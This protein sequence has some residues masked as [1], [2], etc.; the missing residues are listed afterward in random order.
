MKETLFTSVFITVLILTALLLIFSAMFEIGRNIR[1]DEII[2][3]Y[4]KTNDIYWCLDIEA[5]NN[6]EQ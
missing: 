5:D 1:K 6:Y 2:H 3:C 4:E